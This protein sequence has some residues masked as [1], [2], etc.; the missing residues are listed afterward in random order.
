MTNTMAA[1]VDQGLC[2]LCTKPARPDRLH[3]VEHSIEVNRRRKA[4]HDKKKAPSYSRAGFRCGRCKQQ[5]H[6]RRTCDLISSS[7][8][9]RKP[10][11][12]KAQGE[13]G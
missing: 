7:R 1:R 12:T 11:D 8:S 3:C 5:G 13:R 10:L 6:D 9:S 2:L 4:N